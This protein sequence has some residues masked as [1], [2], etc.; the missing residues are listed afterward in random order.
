MEFC[1]NQGKILCPGGTRDRRSKF[2]TVPGVLGRLARMGN[3]LGTK[4]FV[5]EMNTGAISR[6]LHIMRIFEV[7]IVCTV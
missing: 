6:T 4:L 3:Y 5:A 2:G 7:V 1:D